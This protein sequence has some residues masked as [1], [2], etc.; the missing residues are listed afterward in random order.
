MDI[1]T[2]SSKPKLMKSYHGWYMSIKF[3][4]GPLRNS[5]KAY[6]TNVYS[7]NS[8][9]L[10]YYIPINYFILNVSCWERYITGSI[11]IWVK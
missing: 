3:V 2:L 4:K 5:F 9:K 6:Y 10:L 11:V 8:A 1:I 7:N